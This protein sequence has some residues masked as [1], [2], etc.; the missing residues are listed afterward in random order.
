MKVAKHT[1]SIGKPPAWAGKM[2][3]KDGQ[4]TEPT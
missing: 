3:Q 1:V 2:I 4:G